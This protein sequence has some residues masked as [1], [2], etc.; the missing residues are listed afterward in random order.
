MA[1]DH[2]IIK[3]PPKFKGLNKSVNS[4][5]LPTGYAEEVKNAVV[6]S[7][8]SLS[9]RKGFKTSLE[10]DKGI[11]G[12]EVYNNVVGNDTYEELIIANTH[13]NKLKKNNFTVSYAKPYSNSYHSLYLNPDTETYF[14]EI[15]DIPTDNQVVKID[16][17][18]EK[19]SKVTIQQLLDTINST[20]I[21]VFTGSLGS[22]LGYPNTYQ[23]VTTD[24]IADNTIKENIFSTIEILEQRYLE[25]TGQVLPNLLQS[26]AL[27][28]RLIAADTYLTKE[29]KSTLTLKADQSF[30]ITD[31]T[32][33]LLSNYLQSNINTVDDTSTISLANG[34]SWLTDAD[35][36]NQNGVLGLGSFAV[37]DTIKITNTDT[38]SFSLEVTILSIDSS[39]SATIDT[40]QD[41]HALFQSQGNPNISNYLVRKSGNI[42]ANKFPI[43]IVE[44]Y[45]GTDELRGKIVTIDEDDIPVLT[46]LDSNGNKAT[47]TVFRNPYNTVLT[48]SSSTQIP[49]NQFY[50][51]IATYDGSNTSLPAASLSYA[52]RENLFPRHSLFTSEME[53]LPKALTASQLQLTAQEQK[54]L[55][56][57]VIMPAYEHYTDA[58]ILNSDVLRNVSF[59]KINNVLYVGNGHDDMWK[60]D[61]NLVYKPGLPEFKP[62]F[63]SSIV[64][65]SDQSSIFYSEDKDASLTTTS[66]IGTNKFKYNYVFRFS[67]E[68]NK[69]N[70]ITGE[71]S[72]AIEIESVYT[73]FKANEYEAD[74]RRKISSTVYDTGSASLTILP[75][76]AALDSYDLAEADRFI[77]TAYGSSGTGL[78][79]WIGNP[80]TYQVVGDGVKTDAN[81][82]FTDRMVYYKSYNNTTYIAFPLTDDLS[83]FYNGLKLSLTQNVSGTEYTYDNGGQGYVCR[84]VGVEDDLVL[85]AD[86]SNFIDVDLYKYVKIEG[87]HRQVT[88]E[89]GGTSVT[90]YLG[91]YKG[92]SSP[93]GVGSPNY[94]EHTA[95]TIKTLE[96]DPGATA[97]STGIKDESPNHRIYFKLEDIENYLI[98]FDT[99]TSYAQGHEQEK[100]T[101][102]GSIENIALNGRKLQVEIYRTKMYNPGGDALEVA[103]QYYYI[104]NL[105]YDGN[106]DYNL[107][108]ISTGSSISGSGTFDDPYGI[109]V[110]SSSIDNFNVGDVVRVFNDDNTSEGEFLVKTVNSTSN[111]ISIY[112]TEENTTGQLDAT[113]VND[114]YIKAA[115]MYFDDNL[116]DEAGKKKYVL[117]DTLDT[118]SIPQY[119]GREVEVGIDASSA[120]RALN[121]FLIFTQNYKRHDT[122]PKGSLLTVFKNCLVVSGNK[123][124]LNNIQYSLPFNVLTGEIGSEYFPADDNGVVVESQQG[125]RING[126]IGIRD[127][128]YIFH[129]SSVH[130]L[131][132]NLA[133][134]VGI[135]FVVDLMSNEGDL[136][137]LNNQSLIEFKNKCL[138]LSK[139]G[140]YTADS[141]SA[142]NEM[143]VAIQSIIKDSTLDFQ[144]ASVFNWSDKRLLLFS[145]PTENVDDYTNIITTEK[146]TIF[147][148]DYLNDA[149]LEWDNIDVTGGIVEYDNTVFFADRYY[150]KDT[151]RLN[152]SI[153]I[154]STGGT[155]SD[156]NDN[157]NPIKFSYMTNFES[158]NAP[159]V[160][161]KFLRLKLHTFDNSEIYTKNIGNKLQIVLHTDYIKNNKGA[162]NIDAS[163]TPFGEGMWNFFPWG[164][165]LIPG[166]KH[167]LLRNK[168]KSLSLEFKNESLGENVKLN[169]YELEIAAPFR[170]EIKE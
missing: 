149:W 6:N 50:S 161:K 12:M 31:P 36:T 157:L 81:A 25:N 170:Q 107:A 128:L 13:L 1:V 69:G 35:G 164:G 94:Q 121:P 119:R 146:N 111:S 32:W 118:S 153:N 143:S 76:V 117:V 168:S 37:G 82:N 95:I 87:D 38:G 151:N 54:D 57:A 26:G 163:K 15:Y 92:D 133:N 131:I 125:D 21:Q 29:E 41:I 130:S 155:D 106:L 17:G 53:I 14:Y 152:S 60:Y 158:L 80:R 127:V 74:Y 39:L 115:R 100:K 47:T 65:R 55:K 16:L 72:D 27:D 156:Y 91:G 52:T 62:D 167:K 129:D 77:Y 64:D 123:D 19:D 89:T 9:K 2:K 140:F 5:D 63:I 11:F 45:T 102:E 110:G 99:E 33:R 23:Y 103:G 20:A 160:F 67:Y 154:F 142:L 112:L 10:T 24:S 22:N 104:G 113:L 139:K 8:G 86:K 144:R 66:G 59:A 138:F 126:I 84:G 96:Q 162:F 34:Y 148:Y 159:T 150:V 90:H 70:F 147:I 46:Y 135:P 120:N 18:T 75:Y 43:F 101:S 109:V 132:G 98:D 166:L 78:F 4:T 85:N 83:Q 28:T 68:D 137:T 145:I 169:T 71:P 105:S 124:N 79:D 134:P 49:I 61:G 165:G 44:R 58:S 114:I 42:S 48:L 97:F 108:E 56:E 88:T 3:H 40:S 73:S 93:Y 51:Y 30:L 122:P 7:D 141:S 116:A 136:G